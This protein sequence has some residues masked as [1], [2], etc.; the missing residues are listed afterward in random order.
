MKWHDP[1]RFAYSNLSWLN[2][3]FTYFFLF[4]VKSVRL[5]QRENHSI[6]FN[7]KSA[8]MFIEIEAEIILFTLGNS[9]CIIPETLS[10]LLIHVQKYVLSHSQNT[11]KISSFINKIRYSIEQSGFLNFW[12]LKKLSAQNNNEIIF[13]S[14]FSFL[15]ITHKH[16]QIAPN[17]QIQ[18]ADSQ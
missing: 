1:N 6:I 8:G 9:I 5:F 13:S 15:G 2:I 11:I 17:D 16:L 12:Y 18:W 7:F 4:I 10:Y 3:L 14:Y